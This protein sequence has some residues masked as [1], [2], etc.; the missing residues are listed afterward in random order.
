METKLRGFHID[1]TKKFSAT[2]S[3]YPQVQLLARLMELIVK[4]V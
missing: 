4:D 1:H 3:Q 2:H